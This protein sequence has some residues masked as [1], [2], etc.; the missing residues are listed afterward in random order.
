MFSQSDG[1]VHLYH[2]LFAANKTSIFR[3]DQTDQITYTRNLLWNF[4]EI[5]C[6]EDAMWILNGYD[7]SLDAVSYSDDGT[8]SANPQSL[9]TTV[10]GMKAVYLG[11]ERVSW[12]Y[13]MPLVS[14]G[15][16][17]S[18]YVNSRLQKVTTTSN[19]TTLQTSIATNIMAEYI[20]DLNVYVEANTIYGSALGAQQPY[21]FSESFS[22]FSTLFAIE[23]FWAPPKYYIAMFVDGVFAILYR[24]AFAPAPIVNDFASTIAAK[25]IHFR[26]VLLPEWNGALVSLQTNK[27][28]IN[29]IVLVN[30]NQVI[31]QFVMD[32]DTAVGIG[33]KR[34]AAADVIDKPVIGLDQLD[35]SSFVMTYWN[36][37][38]LKSVIGRFSESAPVVFEPV[39][40]VPVE[41]PPVGQEVIVFNSTTV[42]TTLVL[43]N[44][45][46]LVVSNEAVIEVTD[47]T[48]LAGKLKYILS[49]KQYDDLL[50]KETLDI[51]VLLTQCANGSFDS[52]EVIFEGVDVGCLDFSGEPNLLPSQL[53]LLV[54]KS[55]G[56]CNSNVI[57]DTLTTGAI[58]GIVVGCAA[59]VV[60]IIVLALYFSPLSAKVFPY[61][62]K[63]K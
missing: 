49:Q 45:S 40:S 63:N 33:V 28:A 41:S 39:S 19:P 10:L 12:V 56:D 4:N 2:H 25:N 62:P 48:L 31:N 9:I 27:T 13:S 34:E 26:S 1:T 43:T 14:G 6:S 58:I 61:A 38:A 7:S 3:R 50:D 23:V 47:C 30:G 35:N 52:I 15:A 37:T 21:Q 57:D 8:I 20:T 24:E 59:A 22:G 42:V 17:Q 5:G 36:G 16:F 53:T 32:L 54:T 18:S 11:D 46:V 60:L 55:K 51:L 44:T 29:L